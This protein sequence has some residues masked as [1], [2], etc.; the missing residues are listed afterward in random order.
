MLY[1]DSSVLIK[2][3]IQEPGA[4]AVQAKIRQ[5]ISRLQIIFISDIGYAEILAAF[6]RKLRDKLLRPGEIDQI[7]GQ[8]HDDWLFTVGRVELNV[9]VLGFIQ[10]L[11]NKYPLRGADAIH[12]ASALWLKDALRLGKVPGPSGGAMEF[13]SSDKQLK[14]A[15]SAEGL[16]IFDPLNPI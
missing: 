3:Y 7:Q 12:L 5:E 1:L 2:K 10:D 8:F 16:K 15:A 4:P 6:A 11:V 13:A 9:G 14:A